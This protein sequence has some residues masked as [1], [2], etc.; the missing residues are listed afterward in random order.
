M[1]TEVTMQ[2]AATKIHIMVQR[3]KMHADNQWL[4]TIHSLYGTLLALK[5]SVLHVTQLHLIY[6]SWHEKSYTS[7]VCINTLQ[8]CHLRLILQIPKD[9]DRLQQ[10]VPCLG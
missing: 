2:R 7:V 4:S 6:I 5:L 1:C 10:L 8:R 9:Q 3:F